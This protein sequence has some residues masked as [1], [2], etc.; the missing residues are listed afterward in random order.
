MFALI[1]VNKRANCCK[2]LFLKISHSLEKRTRWLLLLNL[3]SLSI[4]SIYGCV[5][6]D[7]SNKGCPH[8]TDISQKRNSNSKTIR[9]TQLF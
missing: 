3:N 5:T 7:K 4:L 2:K 6:N 1:I 8:L 9:P